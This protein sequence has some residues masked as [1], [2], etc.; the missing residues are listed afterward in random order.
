MYKTTT[1]CN[2]TQSKWC[3]NKH[4]PSKI[5]DTFETYHI[6]PSTPC[7]DHHPSDVVGAMPRVEI[8]S[9]MR[10]H[11]RFK[12]PPSTTLQRHHSSEAPGPTAP[13]LAAH[14]VSRRMPLGMTRREGRQNLDL[15]TIRIFYY[16]AGFSIISNLCIIRMH[17]TTQ[18]QQKENKKCPKQVIL[19]KM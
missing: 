16:T 8:S 6:F 17:T 12:S 14:R 2:K 18:V 9:R 15:F 13:S 10:C 4:G 11:C 19:K 5:I 7:W 3:I 1:K